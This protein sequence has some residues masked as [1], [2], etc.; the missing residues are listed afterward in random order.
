MNK[1]SQRVQEWRK[2][3]WPHY[4]R[5]QRAVNRRYRER[6]RIV[7]GNI[8]AAAAEETNR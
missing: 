2:Q 3:N 6:Q 1:E 8:A 4:L 5:T 7:A